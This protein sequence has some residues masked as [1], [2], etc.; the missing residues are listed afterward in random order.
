MP[1]G[2]LAVENFP[3]I[4]VFIQWFLFLDPFCQPPRVRYGMTEKS[5]CCTDQDF[6]STNSPFYRQKHKIKRYIFSA[7]SATPWGFCRSTRGAKPVI[8]TFKWAM[9]DSWITL[10]LSFVGKHSVCLPSLLC[11][12]PVLLWTTSG[13]W[14]QSA[15]ACILSFHYWLR[16]FS[17]NAYQFEFESSI[18]S[19]LCWFWAIAHLSFAPVFC[20]LRFLEKEKN[21]G[22]KSWSWISWFD[23]RESRYGSCPAASSPCAWKWSEDH[24]VL[25]STM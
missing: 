23:G 18:W 25:S 11:R 4:L 9:W 5:A 15:H 17:C 14:D 13:K 1:T 8:V 22:A 12:L 10:A 20:N 24:K 19:R 7:R 3:L 16:L 21:K 6:R 2:T